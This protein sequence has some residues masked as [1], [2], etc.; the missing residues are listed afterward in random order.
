MR[1]VLLLRPVSRHSAIISV[2]TSSLG[3]CFRPA[4]TVSRTMRITPFFHIEPLS[5]MCGFLH[6]WHIKPFGTGTIFAVQC[7]KMAVNSNLP[8]KS[9]SLPAEALKC[10]NP[11][12]MISLS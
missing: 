4:L 11:I 2:F 8:I 3:V 1:I 7:H 5:K 6:P 9:C 10:R 12:A